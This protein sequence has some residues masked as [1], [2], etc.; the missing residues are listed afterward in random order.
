MRGFW[1]GDPPPVTVVTVDYPSGTS[2]D[3][4][5]D[6]C[7]LYGYLVEG[8]LEVEA[9]G[10]IVELETG[11]SVALEPGSVHTIRNRHGSPARMVWFRADLT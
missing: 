10:A 8:H 3:P 6:R 11:G 5:A 7:A 1:F 2:S 9:D 4:L